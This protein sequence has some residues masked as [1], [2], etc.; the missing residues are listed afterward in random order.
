MLYA[1]EYLLLVPPSSPP[2]PPPPPSPPVSRFPS[3]VTNLDYDEHKGRIAIGRVHSGRVT[4]GQAVKVC[5]PDG[6]CR[7]ARIAELLVFD[8]FI[9]VPAESVAAGDICAL[10]G[11]PDVQ[12]RGG[13]RRGEGERERQGGA[14]GEGG[15]SRFLTRMGAGGADLGTCQLNAVGERGCMSFVH[16]KVAG[17]YPTC[18]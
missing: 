16:C 10:S 8:N 17:G 6:S 7:A 4:R 12:V 18:T 11:L 1:N 14:D 13:G 9:R 3:Q 5:L 15:R 2:L